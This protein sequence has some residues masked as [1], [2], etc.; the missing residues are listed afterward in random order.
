MRVT[1]TRVKDILT[2]T[3]GFLKTVTSHSVQ[4]YRGCSYGNSLCG[5][6]CYVQHNFWITKGRPWGSFLEARVNAAEAYCASVVRER[7][8]AERQE[9]GAFGIFMSSSTDPFVPQESRHGI[10]RSLLDAMRD[11]PPDTLIVQ[12][13]SHGVADEVERLVTLSARCDLRVHISIETDRENV[14]GLPRHASSVDDRF[15]AARRLREAGVYVVVTVAP[16]LPIANPERFFERIA[17]CA[18]AV[19]IDHF[20]KGDGSQDGRRTLQTKLPEAIR[21]IDESALSLEYR[22][23]MA[24]VAEGVMP[25]RVGVHIDGFAGRLRSDPPPPPCGYGGQASDQ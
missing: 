16:L 18:D 22:E 3:T 25:G 1:E 2:R 7:R 12:T 9:G 21:E 14:P 24:A 4:P 6:G 8:W 23:R 20:V 15:E 5:V 17:S 11:A 13:H 10:T 19:V